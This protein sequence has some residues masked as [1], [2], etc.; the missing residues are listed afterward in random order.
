MATNFFLW[1]DLVYKVFELHIVKLNK[2]QQ[3]TMMQILIFCKQIG[4]EFK[5]SE[6]LE[7]FRI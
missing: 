6:T 3:N 1:P 5:I 7:S 2:N 4:F